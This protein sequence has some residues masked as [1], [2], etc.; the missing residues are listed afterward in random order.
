MGQYG[1]EFWNFRQSVERVEA[2]VDISERLLTACRLPGVSI[3]YLAPRSTEP[4]RGVVN[5]R[6]DLPPGYLLAPD[7]ATAARLPR[8]EFPD[9]IVRTVIEIPEHI[10]LWFAPGAFFSLV[11]GVALI[12]RGAI[13]AEA[14]EIFSLPDVRRFREE[15]RLRLP[16]VSPSTALVRL[17]TT[18]IEEVY[19]E[20]FGARSVAGGAH[21]GVVDAPA[22]TRGFQACIHAACRDRTRSGVSLPPLTVVCRGIYCTQD[23]L[24]ALPTINGQGTLWLRGHGDASTRGVGIPAI[25]RFP[26]GTPRGV[27]KDNQWLESTETV[28]S[29]LLWVHPRV[30]LDVDGVGLK[31]H[32]WDQGRERTQRYDVQHCVRIE[33]ADGDL[34]ALASR[35]VFFTQCGLSGGS[36]SIVSIEER[37][38]R[39]PVSLPVLA[40]P[41]LH[42]PYERPL[43]SPPPR[44]VSRRG[45]RYRFRGC[46]LDAIFHA[47]VDVPARPL[48]TRSTRQMIRAVQSDSSML[49]V[50]GGKVHQNTG[51]LFGAQVRADDGTWGVIDLEAGLYLQGGCGF[52]KS[53]TFHLD[54]GPRPS[55]PLGE[56]NLPDGQDIWLDAGAAGSIGTHLTVLHADSQSWW[57]LGGTEVRGDAKSAVSLLNVGANDV[58]LK[59]ISRTGAG[60]HP[61]N[62]VY[63]ASRFRTA[64]Q[65]ARLFLP[66]TVAWSG[67]RVPLLMEGCYFQR[68][69]TSPGNGGG[70]SVNI[71]SSFR[72]TLPETTSLFAVRWMPSSAIPRRASRSD[73]LTGPDSVVIIGRP[74]PESYRVV[75]PAIVNHYP[76]ELVGDPLERV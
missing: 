71:G 74:I 7:A 64:D 44:H 63:Q 15:I 14:T 17:E 40:P 8:Q 49:S 10:T 41:T 25:Q 38:V 39:P 70:L 33:G 59:S 53:V 23:T 29:A 27:T 45:S 18:Q 1:D 5:G 47:L 24:E 42:T 48:P 66:P 75:N 51:A 73:S 6:R 13:R 52:V 60:A 22:T 72:P 54:E 32:A 11:E 55:R 28:D 20:W 35:H 50:I 19:P 34:S 30:S 57:F 36:A 4:S 58:N 76:Y 21:V 62:E 67:G 56:E 16:D 12:I 46:S 2:G 9:G 68:Y 37:R 65:S 31:C 61:R 3:L 69:C 26:A 43:R